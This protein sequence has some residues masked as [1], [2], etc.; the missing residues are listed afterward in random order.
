MLH[1]FYE[2]TECAKSENSRKVVFSTY[3]R[4]LALDAYCLYCLLFCC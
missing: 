4:L 1:L 3:W 2:V